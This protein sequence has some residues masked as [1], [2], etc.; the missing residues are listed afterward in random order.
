VD[1]LVLIVFKRRRIIS[2]KS[3]NNVEKLT[4]TE[5][6]IKGKKPNFFC[7]GKFKHLKLHKNM[8]LFN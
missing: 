4:N 2:G 6:L 1:T 5:M 3:V 7:I 8:L